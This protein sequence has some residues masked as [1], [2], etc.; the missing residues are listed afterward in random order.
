MKEFFAFVR[1]EFRHIL[2]DKRTVLILLAMPIVQI[3]L[4]GFALSNE[5]KDV[6]LAV[7][8]NSVDTETQLLINTIEASEYFELTYYVD[9]NL[10]IDKLLKSG[11]IDAAILFPSDFASTL[12]GENRSD[13]Q[14]I[15]DATDPNTSSM[16][17][18]L[19]ETLSGVSSWTTSELCL[20]KT[21]RGT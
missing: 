4:F 3:I 5:V 13:V 10:E 16:Y 15:C 19:L 11:K 2:R 17:L 1:K 8:H 12:R 7:L 20:P 21:V 18:G 6:R 14:I 9:N